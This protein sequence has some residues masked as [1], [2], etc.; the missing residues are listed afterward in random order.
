LYPLC[1]Q[2]FAKAPYFS[3][4][5]EAAFIQQYEGAR[6]VLEY[7]LS[8][9][10]MH[11]EVAAGF[12]LAY[13]DYAAP[14]RKAVII[15]TIARHPERPVPGLTKSMVNSVYN[16]ARQSGYSRA[17]HAFMHESNRSVLRSEAYGGKP[18][19]RYAVFVKSLYGNE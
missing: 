16:A 11:G 13:P 10:A 5:T 9:I 6:P 15:K 14:E 3:P 2:A 4:L 17:I 7:G 8:F 12:V 18:L 19:R 1:M